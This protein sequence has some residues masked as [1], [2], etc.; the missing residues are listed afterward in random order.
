MTQS[1]CGGFVYLLIE[2]EFRRLPEAR[3]VY[4]IG[5]TKDVVERLRGYPKGSRAIA[6]VRVNDPVAAEAAIMNA[7]DGTFPRRPDIGREYYGGR[8]ELLATV[9]FDV[10]KTHVAGGSALV[11]DGDEDG[12]DVDDHDD[13]VDVGNDHVADACDSADGDRGAAVSDDVDMRASAFIRVFIGGGTAEPGP[14]K[15]EDLH[16]L[17]T[18]WLRP[19]E[20]R[21]TA[22]RLR[23]IAVVGFGAT[24]ASSLTG[25]VVTFAR[26]FRIAPPSQIDAQTTVTRF[27]HE[28]CIIG[29]TERESVVRMNMAYAAW[30]ATTKVTA[31]NL[32][33]TMDA[34]GF[35]KKNARVRGGLPTKAYIGVRLA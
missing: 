27:L 6:V 17:Y 5:L 18:N 14:I 23:S 30:I 28:R 33:A 4:K 3:R 11:E 25:E 31:A 26:A 29:D 20:R 13:A 12:E 34:M 24:T 9:F 21:L 7:F 10:V 2:R 1:L 16:M 35:V 19:S 15:L 8:L 22:R 32:P